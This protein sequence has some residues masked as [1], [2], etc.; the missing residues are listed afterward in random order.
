MAALIIDI[1]GQVWIFGDVNKE[2]NSVPTHLKLSEKAISVAAG[3][4]HSL[5]LLEN[6]HIYAFGANQ[7]G[8]LGDMTLN[9]SLVPKRIESLIE[10]K[11]IQVS[12]G[13]HHSVAIS[14]DGLLFTFGYNFSGQCGIGRGKGEKI[15]TPQLVKLEGKAAYIDCGHHHNLLILT[16]KSLM[17]WGYR[18]DGRLGVESKDNQYFPKIIEALKDKKMIDCAGGRSHSICIDEDGDV[19]TFGYGKDYQLGHLHAVNESKPKKIEFFIN[20]QIKAKKCLAGYGHSGVISEENDLYI[21]GKTGTTDEMTMSTPTK[22]A[23]SEH[24]TVKQ[25]GMGVNYTAILIYD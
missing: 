3:N 21:F 24:M 11:M 6:G 12:A 25:A 20:N 16:N 8:E 5:I 7:Y 4:Y 2:S 19:W 1:V 17:S 9:R 18:Y 15:M 22:V 13:A 14:K 10:H 23:L